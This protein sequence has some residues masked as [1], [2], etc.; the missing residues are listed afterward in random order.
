MP[1]RTRRNGALLSF[2]ALLVTTFNLAF[3]V[4]VQAQVLSDPRMAEFDPSPD[5]WAM[6]DSGQPTVLRYEL[7]VYMVGASAPFTTVD[8]GKPSPDA[9]GKIRYDFSSDVAGWPLPG[10]NYEARVSAVGP[11]GSALSD[12]SN[13]FTFTTGVPCTTSLSATT[14]PVPASGGAYV[15]DVS[16]GAGCEWAATTSL[17]WV[18]L[19]TTGGSGSGTVPFDVGANSSSSSRTGTIDIGGQTLT[20]LQTGAAP[21]CSYSVSPTY[22]SIPYAGGSGEVSV[23]TDPGCAWTVASS[24]SWLAPSVRSGTGSASFTFT[25]RPNFGMAARTARLTVGP[26]NVEVFQ[27]GRAHRTK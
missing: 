2:T 10:G 13:P 9:D 18:T 20:V 25:A 21:S 6:L 3:A 15:V 17:S 14:A 5:H 27:S 16:T 4:T 26:W 11:E 12:P 1:S 8:L 24:H 22:V 23:V 7:G 19:W